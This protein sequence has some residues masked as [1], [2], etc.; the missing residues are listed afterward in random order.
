MLEIVLALHISTVYEKPTLARFE[1]LNK[2]GLCNCASIKKEFS[3]Y[4]NKQIEGVVVPVLV[5]K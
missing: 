4:M 3:K 2:Y 5:V 1:T